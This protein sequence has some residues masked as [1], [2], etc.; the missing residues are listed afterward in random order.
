MDEMFI[1]L[2]GKSGYV[3]KKNEA[4]QTLIVVFLTGISLAGIK[5]WLRN[6]DVFKLVFFMTDVGFQNSF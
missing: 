3:I 5:P 6:A 4:P 1:L 2:Q